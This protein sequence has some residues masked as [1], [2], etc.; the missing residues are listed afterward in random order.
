MAKLI[1]QRE[2]CY[3]VLPVYS[4][5]YS[6]SAELASGQ[7]SDSAARPLHGHHI[8]MAENII[9]VGSL[10]NILMWIRLDG[11]QREINYTLS[12]F[13]LFADSR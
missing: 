10:E 5:L 9:Y 8:Q 2:L 13:C 11:N 4:F 1:A 6:S 7:M 12:A 3:S